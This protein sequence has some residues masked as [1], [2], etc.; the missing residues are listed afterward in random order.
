MITNIIKPQITF[1]FDYLKAVNKPVALSGESEKEESP[2]VTFFTTGRLKLSKTGCISISLFSD[3]TFHLYKKR[4][5]PVE[6]AS[7]MTP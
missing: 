5:D 3:T 1:P 7:M 6:P 4:R 2:G